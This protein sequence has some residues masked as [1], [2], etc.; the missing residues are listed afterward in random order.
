MYI[1]KSVYDFSKIF[2]PE[3]KPKASCLL[4]KHEGYTTKLYP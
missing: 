4:G 1:L 2:V 3:I